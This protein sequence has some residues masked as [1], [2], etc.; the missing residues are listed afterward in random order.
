MFALIRQFYNR[1]RA[2]ADG[3]WNALRFILNVRQGLQQGCNLSP[4]LF[5]RFFTA[6]PMVALDEFR[7]DEGVMADMV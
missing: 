4:L 1:M 7:N 6:M 2:R 5:S 3:Q